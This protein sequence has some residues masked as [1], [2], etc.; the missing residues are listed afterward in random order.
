MIELLYASGLRISELVNA[1]LENLD[2]EEGVIRVT[3]KGNKTRLVPVGRRAIKS[4]RRY[5][6][7]ERPNLVRAADGQRGVPLGAG[8]RK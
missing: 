8:D 6:E 2:L 4:L 7:F 3:G 1:R 5:L